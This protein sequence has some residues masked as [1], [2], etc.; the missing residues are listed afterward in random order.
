MALAWTEDLTTGID[1]IDHQHLRIVDYINR[2][3]E[4]IL[5]QDR[6]FVGSVLGELMDYTLS[7]LAFEEALQEEAGYTMAK[8]HKAVHD[9]FVKRIEKYLQKYEAGEDIATKVHGTLLTWLVHHIKRDDMAYVP[10]VK[11]NSAKRLRDKKGNTW[12]DQLL[13]RLFR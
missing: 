4:A 2:L 7:H 13:G 10:V 12:L 8:Q 5:M 11:A 3:E 6:C 1:V 9:G